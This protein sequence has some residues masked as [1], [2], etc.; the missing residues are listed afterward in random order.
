MREHG[1]NL[2]PDVWRFQSVM[3]VLSD[4]RADIRLVSGWFHGVEVEIIMLVTRDADGLGGE[5]LAIL[6]TV[7]HDDAITVDPPH[8]V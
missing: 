6:A 7:D 3:S 8:T 4:R 5:P 2:H 1:S